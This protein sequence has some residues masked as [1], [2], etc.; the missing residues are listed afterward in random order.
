VVLLIFIISSSLVSLTVIHSAKKTFVNKV[1]NITF[2][3]LKKLKCFCQHQLLFSKNCWL[4]MARYDTISVR[5]WV[6]NGTII[7]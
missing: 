1:T 3:C 7:Y 5:F 2:S 6:S 4:Q